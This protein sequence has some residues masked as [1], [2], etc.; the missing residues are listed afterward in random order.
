MAILLSCVFAYFSDN[1]FNMAN[2]SG[3]LARI[4]DESIKTCTL[5]SGLNGTEINEVIVEA[6]TLAG[7]PAS[8]VDYYTVEFA[9]GTYNLGGQQIELKK[10][11]NLKGQG[12]SLTILDAETQSR[13]LFLK[14][15]DEETGVISDLTV[16]GGSAFGSDDSDK[17]GGG[18][19]NYDSN[20]NIEN[21]TISNNIAEFKGGGI[22]SRYLNSNVENITINNN[23]ARDGGGFYASRS[24]L[25]IKNVVINNNTARNIAGIKIANSSSEILNSIIN[26]NIAEDNIG[27]ISVDFSNS[28]IINTLITNNE[29][30]LYGGISVRGSDLIIK[31]STVADNKDRNSY[32]WDSANL[33]LTSSNANV[34]I[35]NSI[36]TSNQVYENS[37]NVEYNF[38]L[39]NLNKEEIFASQEPGDYRILLNSVAHNTGDPDIIDP[40]G[41]GSDMGAYG[42]PGALDWTENG[43]VSEWED[44]FGPIDA[45]LCNSSTRICSVPLGANGTEI[46]EVIVE[47]STLAGEPASSEDY[48]TVEFAEGNYNLGGQ[49]I[50][51]KKYV[52]LLGQG[53]DLT[54][55]DANQLSRVLFVDDLTYDAGMISELGITGGSVTGTGYSGSGGGI[56]NDNSSPVIT[57]VMI[58]ANEAGSG[59]GIYNNMSS[60]EITNVTIT[61]NV[62]NFG[63]GI[64]NVE[65]NPIITKVLITAN[66]ASVGAGICNADSSPIITNVTITANEADYGG[67]IRNHNSNPVI[68]NV[69]ITANE[70]GSGGGIYNNMSSPE[71][72]NLTISGNTADHGDGIYNN[73]LDYETGVYAS[74]PNILNSI[75]LDEIKNSI[76]SAV[77]MEYSLY[78]SVVAGSGILENIGNIEHTGDINNVFVDSESNNYRIWK[79][80]T[81]HNTGDPE[82]LDPDGSISDIGA[83]GGPGALDWTENGE[84]QEWR[85]NLG[86]VLGAGDVNEDGVLDNSDLIIMTNAYFG[87]ESLNDNAL[88]NAQSIINP[89]DE[90]TLAD[91]ISLSRTL[92]NY[93]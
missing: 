39:L 47:A 76:N 87:L 45:E 90:F 61:A 57:N 32:F 11:V 1:S 64:N 54:I 81:A 70:A 28:K 44:N 41:S 12:E 34:N 22:Y 68:T 46:N 78:G 4:C 14:N 40:D 5:P 31:N 18:I 7:E 63:G 67:G 36:I 13:V 56:L 50:E 72:T 69:I 23:N 66:V 10:Y 79:N 86:P 58:T 6:S 83:Y 55:L 15:L 3:N 20:L 89:L 75:V 77:N 17:H 74:I 33:A 52:N 53:A 25:S 42:G 27:G 49:Q 24:D 35:W 93:N 30:Q 82:I 26:N 92:L 8:S 88:L 51:L 48:Y 19:Y 9:E 21:I 38:S 62:A 91:L 16:T 43:A 71:I 59:G 85:T 80:S 2:L 60:P 84:L 65:S 37:G 73:T 29:S